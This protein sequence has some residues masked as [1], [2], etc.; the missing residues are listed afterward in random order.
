MEPY[1]EKP[2][3]KHKKELKARTFDATAEKANQGIDIT[4]QVPRI[5]LEILVIGYD[6]ENMRSTVSEFMNRIQRQILKFKVEDKVRVFFRLFSR[7]KDV[8]LE[9][10]WLVDNAKCKY[11]VFANKDPED[12][13]LDKEFVK[14]MT[15]P[16]KRLESAME[17]IKQ[18]GIAISKNK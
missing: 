3:I 7:D 6:D 5:W 12:F 11:Y 9:K 1:N 2:E 18:H 10:Q 13:Y 4:T 15:M 17:L 8:E 14:N 16:L